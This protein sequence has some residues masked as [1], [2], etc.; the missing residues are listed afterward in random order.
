[1]EEQQEL[2]QEMLGQNNISGL[3]D[4]QRFIDEAGP[5]ELHKLGLT[6]EVEKETKMRSPRQDNKVRQPISIKGT[7][8][9]NQNTYG[10]P[11]DLGLPY[12]FLDCAKP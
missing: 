5:N 6:P 7:K 10:K 2:L 4:L 11:I 9:E 1:M 3:E 12:L 8:L